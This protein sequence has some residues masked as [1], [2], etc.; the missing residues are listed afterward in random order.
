MVAAD[1]SEIFSK[2]LLVLLVFGL[3]HGN[4]GAV[5]EDRALGID[6]VQDAFLVDSYKL[7]LSRLGWGGYGRF[8]MNGMML[9]NFLI[10]RGDVF[11][12]IMLVERS[13]ARPSV[14]YEASLL[15]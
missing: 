3:G 4:R 11:W 6:A 7:L 15:E 14:S 8:L 10:Y 1:T 2:I 5:L 9:G 13:F 12:R